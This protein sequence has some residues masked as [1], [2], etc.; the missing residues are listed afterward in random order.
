MAHRLHSWIVIGALVLAV[1]GC[2]ATT[3]VRDVS[4]VD[5]QVS[6]A[7]GNRGYL[8]GTP[9][10][11]GA[12]K[13]T[14]QMLELILETPFIASSSQSHDETTGAGWDHVQTQPA[15]EA[16]IAPEAF[17]LYTVKEGDS[18]W[19]I[20]ADPANYGK[21]TAWRGIFDANRDRMDAPDDLHAG[22]ELRIPQAE[23]TESR[24][25]ARHEK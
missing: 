21:A 23:A 7:N 18:L 9:P 10:P 8:K 12:R 19:S 4:R 20:A 11:L 25:E 6:E 3:K 15:G 17:D 16:W 14:R 13:T 5:L 24:K 2:R 22:L 1:A